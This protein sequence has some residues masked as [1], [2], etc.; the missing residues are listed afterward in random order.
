MNQRDDLTGRKFHHLTALRWSHR[1]KWGTQHWLCACVCG[2]TK[3]IGAKHLKSGHTKSCGCVRPR[4]GQI[5]RD[6]YPKQGARGVCE[7]IDQEFGVLYTIKQ[8]TEKAYR[9]GIRVDKDAASAR[10]SARVLKARRVWQSPKAI[11]WRDLVKLMPVTPI[12]FIPE[13]Q[14]FDGRK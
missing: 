5:V 10:K 8:I 2:Q 3:A 9:M 14:R 13:S 6:Y 11:W 4:I 12:Q 7:Q 1:D